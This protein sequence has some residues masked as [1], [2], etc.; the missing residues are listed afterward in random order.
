[1][2][3]SMIRIVTILFIT[4]IYCNNAYSQFAGD[5][6]QRTQSIIA[7]PG[8]NNVPPL[9]TDMPLD[10]MVGYIVMDS[11]S[12]TAN[13][14]EVYQKPLTI[15]LDSLQTSARF[16][17]AV[18]DYDPRLFRRYIYSTNDSVTMPIDPN[19]K[20]ISWPAN[21]YYGIEHAI[22]NERLDEF[23]KD[24]ALLMISHY[25]LRVEIDSVV[26]GLDTTVNN[27]KPWVNVACSVTHKI[28]GQIIPSNC[29]YESD[30]GIIDKSGKSDNILVDPSNCLNFGYLE[31]WPTGGGYSDRP[32]R[33]GT[34]MRTLAKGD[35]Y[36]VFLIHVSL[37]DNADILIPV[38]LLEANG[39]L[40]RISNG[41]VED[42]SDIWGLGTSP[43]VAD[44]LTRINSKIA[45]IKTWWVK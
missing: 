24:Y 19:S 42:P 33:T 43:T 17:Y 34:R 15:S 31:N 14:R 32:L 10:C 25:I 41:L 3:K 20:Y 11:L 21:S 5:I 37:R 16:M 30:I 45:T 2:L 38:H 6:Y 26:T 8:L 12:R 36:F 13:W 18:A 35:E 9:I 7:I 27:P 28:K 44:F 40:F 22:I 1:M 23:G 39:G 4:I 29:K